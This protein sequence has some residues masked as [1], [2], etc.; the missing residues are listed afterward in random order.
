MPS[1]PQAGRRP[2]PATGS[3]R[4]SAY[5]FWLSG[6]RMI[7]MSRVRPEE[8]R[9]S[10]DRTALLRPPP[11]AFARQVGEQ[12]AARVEGAALPGANRSR[13]N[14][15]RL[16]SFPDWLNPTTVVPEQ[17]ACNLIHPNRQRHR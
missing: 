1:A 17:V 16:S 10:T 13:Y 6:W 3:Q 12:A 14:D 2:D 11:N 8:R 4:S 7:P 9:I 15:P 5:G